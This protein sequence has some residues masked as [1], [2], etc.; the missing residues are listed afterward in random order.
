MA[1]MIKKVLS[2]SFLVILAS[3]RSAPRAGQGAGGCL[4][5]NGAQ[6]QVQY[7]RHPAR[8]AEEGGL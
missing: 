4:R 5:I 3:C 6:R 8:A 7:R 2:V 1:D